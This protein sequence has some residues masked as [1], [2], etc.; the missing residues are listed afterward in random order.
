MMS[1][2]CVHIYQVSVTFNLIYFCFSFRP[3]LVTKPV[4]ANAWGF[5]KI[6]DADRI[7]GACK[8]NW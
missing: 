2:F 4:A 7:E 6:P 5:I 8:I 3:Q 1:L